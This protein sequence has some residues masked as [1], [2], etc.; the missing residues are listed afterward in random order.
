MSK[1][2]KQL[3]NKQR[4]ALRGKNQIS[5]QWQEKGPIEAKQSAA[6]S[7][8]ERRNSS[9]RNGV[10]SVECRTGSSYRDLN[11]NGREKRK[12]EGISK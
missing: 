3:R 9:C 2:S 11:E 1:G 10:R 6:E 8:V 12:R 7:Q 5:H 4:K